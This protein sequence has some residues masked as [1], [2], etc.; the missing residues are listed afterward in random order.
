[1]ISF[2]ARRLLAAVPLLWGVLTLGA[3]LLGWMA[4]RL[5]REMETTD[6]KR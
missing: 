3:A 4:I 5:Y 1:M 6:G 2:T